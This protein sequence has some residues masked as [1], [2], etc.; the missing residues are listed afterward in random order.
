MVCK[1][2]FVERQKRKKYFKQFKL[3][4]NTQ[5]PLFVLAKLA[6]VSTKTLQRAFDTYLSYPPEPNRVKIRQEV[7]LKVD[8]TYFSKWGCLIV[9]TAGKDILYWQYAEREHDLMYQ[10]GIRWLQSKGYVILGV[11]S[12]WH[13]SIVRA[14]QRIYPHIPHQRCLIHT[15]RQC[16]SIL[17][18]N[19]KTE[20]GQSLRF[21]VL[22]LNHITSEYEKNM[23]IK[24]FALWRKRY[25][26]M[27]KE[28]TYLKT[29]EGKSTWWYTHKNLRK[30][31]R[32]LVSS[33]DHLFLYLDHKNLDKDTNGLEGEFKHLKAKIGAHSGMR[34][35]ERM[36][37]ISW[38]LY[39]KKH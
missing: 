37:Y 3:W 28:R 27:I 6:G 7:W 29:E 22:E 4:I 8:A 21:L 38:N 17:T 25:E 10:A 34:K 13:G 2:L 30:V 26:H 33:Q 14:V 15:Q 20:A 12:D 11:T 16:E 35:F 18:Q 31:Y 36:A 19:P 24:W 23:W 1:R 39:F 32:S 9:Y 5:S